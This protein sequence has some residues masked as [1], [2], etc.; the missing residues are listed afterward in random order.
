MHQGSGQAASDQ[1]TGLSVPRDQ[2]GRCVSVSTE[3]SPLTSYLPEGAG[4]V[5]GGRDAWTLEKAVD[6]LRSGATFVPLLC[7]SPVLKTW[8]SSVP[9][10][11]NMSHR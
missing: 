6:S 4:Y 9:S 1:T 8:V 3:A 2:T 10:H 5:T 7:T 11:G